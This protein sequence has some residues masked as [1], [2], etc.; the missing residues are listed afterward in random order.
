MET[1]HAAACRFF[2]PGDACRIA[3]EAYR[4]AAFDLVPPFGQ[5]WMLD[6]EPYA[7]ASDF[8]DA[9]AGEVAARLGLLALDRLGEFRPPSD[10]HN[11]FVIASRAAPEK[12]RQIIADRET[13]LAQDMH[14]LRG[15]EN[16]RHNAAMEGETANVGA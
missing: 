5:P 9:F 8:V 15:G 13:E 2:T 10:C 12:M 11:P 14:D 7:T 6:G 3:L 4:A 1:D 16:A